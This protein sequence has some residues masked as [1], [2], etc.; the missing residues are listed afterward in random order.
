MHTHN[1]EYTR[2]GWIRL[3]PPLQGKGTG[4]IEQQ[5]AET[6]DWL[7]RTCGGI[8]QKKTSHRTEKFNYFFTAGC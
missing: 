6:M 3:I 5:G 8:Q 1:S 7:W 4:S 2:G